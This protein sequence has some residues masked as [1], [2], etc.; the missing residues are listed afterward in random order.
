MAERREGR[1]PRELPQVRQHGRRPA[2]GWEGTRWAAALLSGHGNVAPESVH[3]GLG[4]LVSGGGLTTRDPPSGSPSPGRARAARPRSG[5]GTARTARRQAGVGGLGAG[6]GTAHPGRPR[7]RHS[8]RRLWALR[9][10]GEQRAERGVARPRAPVCALVTARWAHRGHL[11]STPGVCVMRNSLMRAFSMLGGSPR[12]RSGREAP[13][14]LV[15]AVTGEKKAERAKKGACYPGLRRD[16]PALQ[17]ASP[18]PVAVASGIL[19]T[20]CQEEN[21]TWNRPSSQ[22]NPGA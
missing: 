18:A 22:D 1:G 10:C 3:R 12:C 13:I 19:V 16:G 8:P 20:L 6:L 2:A 14:I 15:A 9:V 5:V 4:E 11:R 17:S 21:P 7:T